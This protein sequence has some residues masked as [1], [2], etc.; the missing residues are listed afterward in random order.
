MS[1][2]RKTYDV[3]FRLVVCLPVYE[4]NIVDPLRRCARARSY[5]DDDVSRPVNNTGAKDVISKRRNEY[6][7]QRSRPRI[8]RGLEK[9]SRPHACL[10]VRDLSAFKFKSRRR[11]R[12][13]VP[14][15][16]HEYKFHI[17]RVYINISHDRPY[18]DNIN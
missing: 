12:R 5:N 2:E 17:I 3:V 14:K 13:N 9:I 1:R 4:W 15:E 18:R 11:R 10:T 8:A 6:I 7:R 16:D